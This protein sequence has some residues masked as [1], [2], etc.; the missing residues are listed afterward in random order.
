MT[1]HLQ[2]LEEDV[3]WHDVVMLLPIVMESSSSVEVHTSGR[4][5]RIGPA[6]A[7]T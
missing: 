7:V 4:S 5:P 6:V 3:K 1:D 2:H